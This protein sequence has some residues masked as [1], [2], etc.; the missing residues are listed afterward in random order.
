M[1]ACLGKAK[2]KLLLLARLDSPRVPVL[3]DER[4]RAASRPAVPR[5]EEEAGGKRAR[6]ADA[7]AAVNGHALA[8][9]NSL[10]QA[11][12]ERGARV[13]IWRRGQLRHGVLEELEA[14]VERLGLELLQPELLAL[15]RVQTAHENIDAL[16]SEPLQVVRQVAP[17]NDEVSGG[18]GARR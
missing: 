5:V 10:L 11:A 13:D 16:A 18:G 4:K 2:Q 7:R 15:P 1:N 17:H 3:A 9:I 6:A 12:H 8:R 14:A